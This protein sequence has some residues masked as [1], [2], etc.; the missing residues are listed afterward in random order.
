MCDERKKGKRL[1]AREGGVELGPGR[2]RWKGKGEDEGSIRT[3][4]E[5]RVKREAK[6]KGVEGEHRPRCLFSSCQQASTTIRANRH[7]V[8]ICDDVWNADHCTRH[9]LPCHGVYVLEGIP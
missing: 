4:E 3:V 1:V 5:D 7:V 8:Y 6:E 9:L 2:G